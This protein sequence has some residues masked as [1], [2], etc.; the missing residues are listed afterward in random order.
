MKRNEEVNREQ[1]DLEMMRDVAR[2]SMGGGFVLPLQHATRREPDNTIRL[3]GFMLAEPD[4]RA[5]SPVVYIG[6]TYDIGRRPL[7]SFQ[8]ET[9]QSLEEVIA[10]G[11]RVN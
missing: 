3:L 7:E 10:A 4:L 5:A 9:Y 11:W 1:R 6:C 2:W 8:V